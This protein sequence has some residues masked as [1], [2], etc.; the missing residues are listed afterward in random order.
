VR[1]EKNDPEAKEKTLKSFWRNKKSDYLCTPQRFNQG[2][3]QE[4]KPSKEIKP[5]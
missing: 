4:V 5:E 2:E 1:K 3:R